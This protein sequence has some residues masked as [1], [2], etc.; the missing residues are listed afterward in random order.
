MLLDRIKH[1]AA[2]LVV[3][4]WGAESPS[5]GS[6]SFAEGTNDRILVHS[7]KPRQNCLDLDGN[8]F[9]VEIFSL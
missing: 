5:F 7:G 2:L 4:P 6:G 9:D 1:R 3:T 8:T